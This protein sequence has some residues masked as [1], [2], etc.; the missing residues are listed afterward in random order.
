MIFVEHTPGGTLA[1]NLRSLLERLHH[2][3][4]CKIKVVER[5]GSKLK[6][7]FPLTKLWEGTGCGRKDCFPCRQ[8]TEEL[9]DCK[10]RNVVYECICTT[11]NPAAL[12]KGSL[13]K[14]DSSNPSLYVGETA[15]SLQERS[16]DHL[17]ALESG[18]QT[19]HI[20]KH[21]EACHG[22]TKISSLYSKLSKPP[23]LH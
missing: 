11:C 17:A 15:R 22:G 12:K 6:D 13:K 3:L 4:G 7:L 10:R 5:T 16:Q 20:L 21:Q 18:N 1:K 8:G 23:N 9:Q 2:H 14:Y 19:S